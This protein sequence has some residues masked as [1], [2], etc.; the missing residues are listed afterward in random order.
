MKAVSTPCFSLNNLG[1]CTAGFYCNNASTV[2]DQFVCPLGHFCPGGTGV[3]IGCPSGTFYNVTGNTA[4]DNCI[5]CTA[6]HYCMGEPTCVTQRTRFLCGIFFV[7]HILAFVLLT[8]QTTGAHQIYLAGSGNGAPDGPC[9]E[10]YY[11]PGG[12]ESNTP[13][14]LLCPAGHFCPEASHTPTVC[15]NGTYSFQDGQAECDPCPA[16]KFC[17]PFYENGAKEPKSSLLLHFPLH[18]FLGIQ[19][20]SA[21]LKQ[22]DDGASSQLR[23]ILT[24]SCASDIL[25]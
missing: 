18:S 23:P 7:P 13:G 24:F 6:G 16:G 8:L 20:L 4:V 19:C 9:A 22:C 15:S 12:E 5:V 2:P 25:N 10:G 3:P 14:H 17:D 21:L 11:C 1:N